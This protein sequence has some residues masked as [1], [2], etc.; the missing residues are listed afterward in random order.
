MDLEQT[1]AALVKRK[2]ALPV[3][4]AER[5]LIDR[6]LTGRLYS[7]K[8][9]GGIIEDLDADWGATAGPVET[10]SATEPRQVLPLRRAGS[11]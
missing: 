5:Q 8:D 11:A 3:E 2:T 1:I 4:S 6:E 7:Y 9:A 10:L